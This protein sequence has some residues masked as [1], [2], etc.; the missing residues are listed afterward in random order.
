[1]IAESECVQYAR[2]GG[3]WTIIDDV[4][5]RGMMMGCYC[6]S[7]LTEDKNIP[8]FHVQG[9]DFRHSDDLFAIN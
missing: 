1:M 3:G 5:K 8:N 7:E 2:L 4:A 6:E 9:I